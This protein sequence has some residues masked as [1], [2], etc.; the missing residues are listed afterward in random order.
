MFKKLRKRFVSTACACAMLFS[1][2]GDLFRPVD[3][4]ALSGAP[5]IDH[6]ISEVTTDAEDTAELCHKSFELYPNGEDSAEVVT[7]DG[8]MPEDA[9]AEAVNV[10]TEHEGIAAYD[11][12]ITDGRDDYQPGE[13]NPV[14]VEIADP[15][16]PDGDVQLWHIHDDGE[17]EEI[18]DFDASQGRI[19]FYATGFSVYEVV[20]DENISDG[21][22]ERL[23]EFG[24]EGY[25]V[26]MIASSDGTGNNG[27]YYLLDGTVENVRNN[28]RTGLQ[29]SN[30]KTNTPPA[31]AVK[32]YFEHDESNPDIKNHFFIYT[33]DGET[34]KYIQMYRDKN[35]NKGRSGLQYV[36]STDKTSFTI[37]VNS[38]NQLH[39]FTKLAVDNSIHYWIR[40]TNEKLAV[41]GYTGADDVTT[42]WITLDGFNENLN[43]FCGLNNKTYGLMSFNGG[44]VGNA[45]M[46]DETNN[47]K[48]DRV[49]VRNGEKTRDLYVSQNSAITEWT[50]ISTTEDNYKLRADSGKYLKANTD[51]TLSL[52]E[53]SDE[54]T[55]FKVTPNTDGTIKLSSDGKYI[56][57]GTDFSMS[58]T[59]S[60]LSFVRK[61]DIDDDDGFTYTARRISISDGSA[62]AACDGQKLIV[63][64]RIWNDQEKK[65]EFFAIDHDG[66]LKQCY[67]SGDKLMWIDD[68]M[69]TLLWEFTV[70]TNADG[71]ENGYYELKNTYSGKYIAP[72]LNGQI[73]SDNKIGIQ[74]QNR[75]YQKNADGSYTYGEYYT[76]IISWDYNYYDYGAIKGD[77]VRDAGGNIISADLTST[78]YA[79]TD[80]S[81]YFAILDSITVNE[82]T[83]TLH[84]VET[85]DNTEFGIVVKMRDYSNQAEQ[86]TVLGNETGSTNTKGKKGIL[87]TSLGEDGYPTAAQTGSSLGQ[88]YGNSASE[89]NHLFIKSIHD[90]EGYFEF[91]S[92]QN[93]ATLVQEDGSIGTDFTVYK[94]LA[95]HDE[96][97]EM[98]TRKHGQF[99]PYNTIKPGV[100]SVGNPQNLYDALAHA[101]PESDPRKYEKLYHIT[102]PDGTTP[103]N[104]NGTY[105]AAEIVNFYNGMEMDAK[106]VQTPSGLDAWGHD[107]IFEFT[108]DD[109][110][111]LYVDGELIIDLGGIHSALDGKVNFRTGEVY[112]DGKGT[113]TLRD[114]FIDHYKTRDGMTQDEAA[115]KAD[116]KF[117]KKT[118]D[119]KECY[120]FNDYT[121]HSMKIYYMERGAGASN[122][123]MRFNLSSVTPGNV[124]LS[125]NLSG[126]EE[127]L[128]DMDYRLIQ[129]PFQIFYKTDIE[130]PEIPLTNTDP[131]DPTKVSVTYQNSTQT[132]KF[133]ESYISPQNNN[134]EYTNVFFVYPNR[135][136]EIHFP[137]GTMYYRIVE[138][139]VNPRIYGEVTV[140]G[141]KDGVQAVGANGELVAPNYEY[142]GYLDITTNPNQVVDV[143]TAIFDNNVRENSMRSLSITKKLYSDR[144]MTHEIS[145]DEDDTPFSIRLY[146]SNGASADLEPA[147]FMKYYVLDENKHLCSWDSATQKF[148]ATGPHINDINTL[149]DNDKRIYSFHTSGNGA[150]SNIPAGYTIQLPGLTPDTKFRVEERDNEIPVGYDLIGYENVKDMINGEANTSTYIVDP[151]GNYPR[152]SAGTIRALFDARM[153]LKNTRGYGIKAEKIWTDKDFTK[154]HGTIHT[155]V[156]F[157]NN[158]VPNTVKEIAAPNTSVTYFFDSL[159]SGGTIDDYKVYEV[160]V[161][162]DGNVTKKPGPNDEL[163][164]T[165]DGTETDYTVSYPTASDEEAQSL[166]KTENARKSLI[167][168]TRKGGISIDLYK[169]NSGD[170]DDVPLAGGQF[171]L[172]SGEEKLG[173]FSADDTGNVT[174]I[175]GFTDGQEYRLTE[176]LSPTGYIGLEKPITFTVKYTAEGY[177][178]DSFTN[179]NDTDDDTDI[180]DGRN[181][182]E[183]STPNGIMTATINIYNKPFSLKAVKTD[184]EDTTVTPSGAHFALH[185]EINSAVG[186]IKN[187]NPMSGYEDL[188]TDADGIIPKIDNTLPAGKYYLVETTPPVGYEKLENDIV[189][190]ISD[191]GIVTM[192]NTAQRELLTEENG[193]YT[194]TVPN[195]RAV[196]NT[197]LTINK[198]I[199]GAFGDKGRDFTFTLSV[200]GADADTE[201]TWSKNGTAQSTA[202][203]TG[204]TFTMKHGDEV[205]ISLPMG[206]DITIT[207]DNGEYSTKFKLG[208]ADAETTATKTFVLSEETTLVVTNSLD[209]VIATGI[210]STVSASMMLFLLPILPIG[211]ILYGRR[212]RRAARK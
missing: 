127:D 47:S 25:Y 169:W 195:V 29:V 201:F 159:P 150:I 174:V 210:A 40:N 190:T 128:A 37:E 101:L 137:D 198:Y 206:V 176:K 149:T 86:N 173:T 154:T 191:R 139:A 78:Y 165:A 92:C 168:N 91:D 111:W 65:Y 2:A 115:A 22:I 5:A 55:A 67:P 10:T 32:L 126:S 15:A 208:D 63:Y 52:T 84:E 109:D 112:Y 8:M 98:A 151:G 132:V 88:L 75:K 203:K 16:I 180:S 177:M 48:A 129:F 172:Y 211:W 81:F 18:T 138:C 9:H 189:F 133:A 182:V 6:D 21:Y 197:Q 90:S 83:D 95:T 42:A 71:S 131:N 204:G 74:M 158:L 77:V 124:M 1:I 24:E 107:V 122:L 49:T 192:A 79:D 123:H 145:A 163:K 57:F 157:G 175:Y 142:N 19:S 44:T 66:S 23:I 144:S 72:Q 140:N 120:V 43:D 26:S 209:G 30:S 94:E 116:G 135:K 161:D 187:K 17:R 166:A 38:K 143:P 199:G 106:F 46:A 162:G 59:A 12:T 45:L 27:P 178:L 147:N 100:Y 205:A 156:Y 108:G 153:E 136:I 35:W 87:S 14:Y 33:L 167:Q 36:S 207:E 61:A 51:G 141:E 53:N 76:D 152:N 69:N 194:I 170:G 11:I 13:E 82:T 155:A 56:N 148:T 193:E 68:A 117:V 184:S 134:K 70:Y 89:V 96:N 104:K 130:A 186:L 121:T 164:I 7:V 196:S 103:K 160:E 58:A 41:C 183:Y 85:V 212:K 200:D 171:E 39:I 4:V 60:S 31:N 34:K 20:K 62:D 113:T 93:T 119:G 64:T 97:T 28:G 118:V 125:K 181:W 146:I 73:L 185:K 188:V 202:L 105:K 54:A 102:K 179:E 99:F 3:A 50:F 110:F 114:I 80:K